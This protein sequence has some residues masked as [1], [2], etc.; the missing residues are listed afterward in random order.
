MLLLKRRVLLQGQMEGSLRID[1]A[2]CVG[3]ESM[4]GKGRRYFILC[5]RLRV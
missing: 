3:G 5:Q 4:T 1:F 2:K